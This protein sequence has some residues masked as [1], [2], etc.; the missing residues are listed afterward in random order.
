[1]NASNALVTSVSRSR[2]H[3][4]LKPRR[5]LITLL[6]GL[7]VQGDA[8]LGATVRHRSRVR[9]N[10]SQANLRQVHLIH[11]EL[12]DEL[13]SAGFDVFP[14]AM[15]ENVTTRGVELLALPAGTRLHIGS[16]ATVELTGLRNPCTQL[17]RIQPGLMAA[18]LERDERGGLVRKAGVM[19]I[20]LSSG[21]VRPGDR[22]RIEL[23]GERRALEPV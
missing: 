11:A 21:D 22:V 23:P 14:G 5:E 12:Y 1:V 13:R 2:E 9:K 20:V 3:G 18:T 19:G 4:P 15:G 17:D 8:H 7:G 10:P 16:D 6:E